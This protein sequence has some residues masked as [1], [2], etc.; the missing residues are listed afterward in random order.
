MQP[1]GRRHLQTPTPSTRAGLKYPTLSPLQDPN[2]C[3]I[4]T[5]RLG[6]HP[7]PSAPTGLAV[8]S[9]CT[10]LAFFTFILFLDA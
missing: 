6:R 8:C 4:T 10:A 7:L 9:V 1:P 2:S 3:S 5:P